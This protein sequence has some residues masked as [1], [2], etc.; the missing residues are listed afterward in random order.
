MK[1][2]RILV[3]ED[4]NTDLFLIREAVKRATIDADLE[5]VR[6]GEEA[7]EYFH[8]MDQDEAVACPD[9]VLLDLNL[10]KKSGTE[11]LREVRA[12]L[13]GRH[14]K[15]LIVSSSS[16]PKDSAM[17]RHY[18]AAGYFQKPS[19]YGDF[20]KLGPLIHNLLEPVPGPQEPTGNRPDQ[21]GASD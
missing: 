12:S 8:R 3:A 5:I 20:M 18:A 7:M 13:R 11:V 4:N 1:R 2:A 10:P 16:A 15:V 14:V 6:D 9:L 19:N 17:A 21:S